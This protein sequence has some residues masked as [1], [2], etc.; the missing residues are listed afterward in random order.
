[1]IYVTL[2]AL[3]KNSEVFTMWLWRGPAQLAYTLPLAL[4]II[5]SMPSYGERRLETY[6]DD[7][8]RAT[9][10][11]AQ[12]SAEA[13]IVTGDVDEQKPVV[14]FGTVTDEAGKPL[15]GV[16]I[17]AHIGLGTLSPGGRTSSASDGT[18]TLRVIEHPGY[19]IVDAWKEGYSETNRSRQGRLH[20]I[21]RDCIGTLR[22]SYVESLTLVFPHQPHRVDFIMVPGFTVSGHLF[23][24]AGRLINSRRLLLTDG[25]SAEPIG[26]ISTFGNF[27]VR[28][29]PC[30]T[31]SF[32][33]DGVRSRSIDFSCPGA[34]EVVL[35]LNGDSLSCEVTSAPAESNDCSPRTSGL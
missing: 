23:G 10:S 19:L 8:S 16:D 2:L 21:P 35:R 17:V 9:P 28:A 31:M 26:V 3:E 29:A 32:E 12:T 4:A 6:V 15:A 22:P 30:K 27:R 33:L 13:P 7:S 20:Q 34:Y 25:E 18:Y 14:V 5:V 24:K 11:G 1:M